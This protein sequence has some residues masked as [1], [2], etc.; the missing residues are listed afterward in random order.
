M[1]MQ[2]VGASLSP[3]IGGWI[4]QTF[5]Y[6]T[7]FVILGAFALVSVTLWIGYAS[8][9]EPVC[10]VKPGTASTYPAQNAIS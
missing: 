7:M 4:A 5:G 8:V 10:A 9:L 2:G 1:T 6:S 3:A